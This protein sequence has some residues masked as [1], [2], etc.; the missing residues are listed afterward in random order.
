M[1]ELF[2]ACQRLNSGMNLRECEDQSWFKFQWLVCFVLIDV[3][4]F[5]VPPGISVSQVEDHSSNQY[6][7]CK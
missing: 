6:Y 4:C 2:L 5:R 1:I 7:K 3:R